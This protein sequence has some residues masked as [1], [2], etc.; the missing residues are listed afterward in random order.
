MSTY[1]LS[2]VSVPLSGLVSVNDT[3]IG[4]LLRSS[5]CFRPLI[6]VS[7]CKREPDGDRYE[8]PEHSGFRPLIGVSFCKQEYGIKL[9]AVGSDSFRPLIGVSFCKRNAS[10]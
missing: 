5:T 10:R 6:G 9:W 4:A 3:R 8:L 2:I 1:F 7:F